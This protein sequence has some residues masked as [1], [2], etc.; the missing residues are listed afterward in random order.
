MASSVATMSDP[1]AAVTRLEV[2]D[3]RPPTAFL[4]R[5]RILTEYNVAVSL[6][7]QDDGRTLKVF[8]GLPP[9]TPPTTEPD[10][11]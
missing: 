10:R 4:P 8:I 1:T 7:Y 5:G 3:H 11:T 6:S 9:R 2:I